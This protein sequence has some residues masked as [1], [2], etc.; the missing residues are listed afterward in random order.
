VTVL[1]APVGAVPLRGG[2]VPSDAPAAAGIARQSAQAPTAMRRV[3]MMTSEGLEIGGA[4]VAD[5]TL[6]RGR[7][8]RGPARTGGTLGGFNLS[9]IRRRR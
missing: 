9:G 3:S 6:R 8:P 7:S 4:Y 5:A 2:F 1:G